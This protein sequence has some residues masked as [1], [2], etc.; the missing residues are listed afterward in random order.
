MTDKK[1]LSTERNAVKTMFNCETKQK[2]EII[3][4]P[5]PLDYDTFKMRTIGD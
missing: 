3:N 2:K 5:G 1:S 4:T